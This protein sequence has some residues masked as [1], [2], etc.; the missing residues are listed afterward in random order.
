[1]NLSK[2]AT[3]VQGHL[4]QAHKH[5]STL[6]QGTQANT[7]QVAMRVQGHLTQAHKHL[8]TLAQGTQANVTG[9]KRHRTR[10]LSR[11]YRGG[12]RHRTRRLSRRHRGGKRHRTRRLPRRHRGG[13]GGSCIPSLRGHQNV[14]SGGRKYSG[15]AYAR[16]MGAVT[17]SGGID[18]KRGGL[19][20]FGL[21]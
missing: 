18:L 5:L 17:Q 13:N 1:M 9:G 8:S 15:G 20:P 10:R 21:Q 12:K 4:T 11:R 14:F 2:L 6:A 16:A 19:F 3:R 7:S